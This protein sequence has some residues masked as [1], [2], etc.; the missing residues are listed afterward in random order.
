MCVCVCVGVGVSVTRV[1]Y[2]YV[3]HRRVFLYFAPNNSII[4][5]THLQQ[6]VSILCYRPHP[7]L[8]R[9]VRQLTGRVRHLYLWCAGVGHSDI[10]PGLQ[11]E[12]LTTP[13]RCAPAVL[14][15]VEPALDVWSRRV[16][17]YNDDGLPAPGDG[18]SVVRLSHHGNAHTARDPTD[19]EQCGRDVAT[20]LRRLG[21]GSGGE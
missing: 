5:M 12:V 10:P 13:L 21:V 8:Q 19:C 4:P 11:T 18:P 15:Q 20:Q 16:Y 17:P 3:L 2:V 9:L 7:G 1:S 14:R 6:H